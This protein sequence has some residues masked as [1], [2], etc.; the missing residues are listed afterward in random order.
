MHCTF[1]FQLEVIITSRHIGGLS[2]VCRVSCSCH[3]CIV[4]RPRY[5]DY[6]LYVITYILAHTL[7]IIDLIII[8]YYYEC[9]LNMYIMSYKL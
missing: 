9:V 5:H 7:K 6:T 4:C 8:N 1:S 3:H 2:A